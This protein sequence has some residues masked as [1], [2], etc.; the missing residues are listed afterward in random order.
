MLR[1]ERIWLSLDHWQY[2]TIVAMVTPMG[3]V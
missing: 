1:K 2:N 3:P